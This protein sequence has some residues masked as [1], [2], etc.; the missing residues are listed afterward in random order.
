MQWGIMGAD[1]WAMGGSIE[2]RAMAAC[3]RSAWAEGLLVLADARHVDASLHRLVS[4]AI[5][6]LDTLA[7]HVEELGIGALLLATCWAGLRRRETTCR[8]S[9]MMSL[10]RVFMPD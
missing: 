2:P 5:E 8:V 9:L 7:K 3:V 1:P 4:N 10:P 6:E